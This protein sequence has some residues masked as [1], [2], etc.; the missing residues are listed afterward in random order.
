MQPAQR[1]DEAVPEP[2]RDLP[3]RTDP[4]VTEV[5]A[6]VG[7]PVGAHALIGRTRFWTPVRA[8]LL[9]AVVMLAIGWFGKA[10]CIQQGPVGADGALGLD[11]SNG[12]QYS[13]MCYS[14]IVP[15]YG[16]ERLD[17][18]EFPYKSSWVQT[19]ADGLPETRYMEYPVLSGLLQYVVMLGAKAWTAAPWLP[20]ALEVVVYFDLMAPVLSLAWL[21]TVWATALSAGRRVWDA[22][23]VAL[24]PLVVVHAF[25]NFDA[26][27]VAFAATGLLAWSRRRPWL[28]GVL[29]GL[30]V[31]TKL[32][33]LFLLGPLLVVALRAGRVRPWLQATGATAA[34]WAVVNLPIALA[35][36]TGWREFFR[37][38]TSRGADP[39]SLYNVVSSFTGWTGF[40]GPLAPGAEPSRLNAISL[41]AFAAVCIA[42][43][44]LGFRAQRRPRVAS[45]A[46]LVVAGFLLTNKVWSPQYSLWL[47][48]LAVLA[49]PHRKALLAWMTLDALVWV[50]RMFYYFGVA[51]KG[52]PEQWFTGAV[53]VRDVALIILC[54]LVIRDI[55]RPD[56][57]V[58][59][60]GGV[61]DPLGGPV[62]GRPDALPRWW[63]R[64]LR[65]VPDQ[66]KAARRSVNPAR[67][68]GQ[69][70]SVTA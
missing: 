4:L 58:V 20:Q 34:T 51:N 53:L 31:A 57:D 40:D 70:S 28:A 61:D 59:R 64:W 17:Q 67:T 50:P 15:L 26:V 22:A 68:E 62:A 24:T 42:V 30:G 49:F 2:D 25:T 5:S 29:L 69:S 11:W 27:A 23:L 35:Y 19:G 55:L 8:M 56:G 9:M 60:R 54:A 65:P 52:L 3:S 1:E 18:G 39:D 41:G 6:L 43:A 47:V 37:L 38:N 63:P 13:S 36:P 21:V 33:P 45:L 48:P 7:G 10:A 66:P 44:L 46:L 14:D 12:R 32:Y 16:A